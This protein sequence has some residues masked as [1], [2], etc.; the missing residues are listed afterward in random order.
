M[1]ITSLPRSLLVHITFSSFLT[2]ISASPIYPRAAIN[3][4]DLASEFNSACWA[5]L[6]VSD[7]LNNPKTG[8]N[9]TTKMCS[10]DSND[11]GSDCCEAHEPWSTC[12][13]R[14]ALGAAGADCTNIGSQFCN[15]QGQLSSAISPSIA[16]QYH[17]V[18]RAI[19]GK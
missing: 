9:V 4:T 1:Q 11:D 12:F 8:W 13:L 18:A 14:L 7:F 2:V 6:G 17:Y 5:Q 10:A 3:C 19:F 15:Y 16:P